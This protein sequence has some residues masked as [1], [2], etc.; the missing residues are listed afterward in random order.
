[1]VAHRPGDLLLDRGPLGSPVTST[2]I[3]GEVE[4]AVPRLKAEVGPEL[5]VLG[6]SKLLQ[7]LIAHELIDEFR[8]WIFP[9]VVGPGKRLFGEATIPAGLT[10]VDS[11][12]TTTGVIFATYRP[13]GRIQRG[14]FAFEEPTERE[15]ERRG[16][17]DA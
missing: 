3:E 11:K 6:S 17:L 7:T 9:V 12:V 14:S 4:T 8:L 16:G 1:V 2:L 5:Q 13:V 10:L 15:I